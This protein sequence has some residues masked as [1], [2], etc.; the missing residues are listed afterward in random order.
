[1]GA[2][3]LRASALVSVILG[4][5]VVCRAHQG[6]QPIRGSEGAQSFHSNNQMHSLHQTPGPSLKHIQTWNKTVFID[7]LSGSSP[8]RDTEE[9]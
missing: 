9:T 4:A 5:K 7:N 3:A 2:H 6:P 1:M 8:L